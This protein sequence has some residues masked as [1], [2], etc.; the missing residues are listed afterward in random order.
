MQCEKTRVSVTQISSK[1]QII[2]T[3]FQRALRNVVEADLV[4]ET[5]LLE[6]FGEVRGN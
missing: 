1:K 2:T 4:S 5:S 3:F 6:A